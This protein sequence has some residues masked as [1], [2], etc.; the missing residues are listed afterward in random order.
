MINNPIKDLYKSDNY[1]RSEL[2]ACRKL[3]GKK[4]SDLDS[5]HTTLI[6]MYLYC[7]ENMINIVYDHIIELEMRNK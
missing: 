3:M 7:S 1:I 6:F 4:E 5:L 2:I